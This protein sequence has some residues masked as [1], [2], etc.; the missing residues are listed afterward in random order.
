VGSFWAALVTGTVPLQLR[1][2]EVVGE[3]LGEISIE[4]DAKCATGMGRALEFVA[5]RDGS[6]GNGSAAGDTFAGCAVAVRVHGIECG[7]LG[8]LFC[9]PMA[10]IPRRRVRRHTEPG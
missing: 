1:G 5:T 9:S 8:V 10:G 6:T 4:G 3:G 7:R 2:D